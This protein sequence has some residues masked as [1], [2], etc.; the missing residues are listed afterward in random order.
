[1]PDAETVQALSK[2]KPTKPARIPRKGPVQ[3]ALDRQAAENKK[4]FDAFK[5]E[6]RNEI[7]TEFSG[8][9]TALENAADR[10]VDRADN[11]VDTA[12]AKVTEAAES[13]G[14]RFERTVKNRPFVSVGLFLLGG[15]AGYLV[16]RFFPDLF[17]LF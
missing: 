17:G 16:G 15:L 12:V 2:Q 14:D 6:V 7:G 5:N 1:M 13:Y 10:I 9:R 3:D 4:Q 11:V 8:I